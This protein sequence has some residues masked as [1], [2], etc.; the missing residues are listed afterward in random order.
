MKTR[1]YTISFKN[2]G[3]SERIIKNFL[4]NRTDKIRFTLTPYYTEWI[5]FKRIKYDQY[6]NSGFIKFLKLI[7][8]DLINKKT[9]KGKLFGFRYHYEYYAYKL[10]KRLKSILN[11]T[12]LTFTINNKI[13]G[14]YGFYDPC[15]YRKNKITAKIISHEPMFLLYLTKKEKKILEE[16]GVIFD[17]NKIKIARRK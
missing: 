15:F 12:R 11:K 16:K 10:S 1:R 17:G 6:K 14:F 7:E 3:K 4:L 13:K 9:K 2:A 8:K 5:N